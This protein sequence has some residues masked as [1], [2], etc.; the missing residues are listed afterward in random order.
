MRVLQ[1]PE[2]VDL[3]QCKESRAIRNVQNEATKETEYPLHN[4]NSPAATKLLMVDVII[5]DHPVSMELDT[6][7]AVTLVSEHTYKSKWPETPLQISS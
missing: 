6:G 2:I 7:S 4:V 5:N 1:I 3:H